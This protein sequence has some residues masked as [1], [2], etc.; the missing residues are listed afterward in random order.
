MIIEITSQAYETVYFHGLVVGGVIGALCGG[1]AGLLTAALCAA[2][3]RGDRARG[4]IRLPDP[5]EPALREF[6]D[7]YARQ[8]VAAPDVAVES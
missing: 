5:G 8:Q 7:R 6:A 4:R 3:G 2:A 1:T